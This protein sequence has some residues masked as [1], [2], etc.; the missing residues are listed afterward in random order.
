MAQVTGMS[1]ERSFTG[2]MIA[3]P[4]LLADHREFLLASEPVNG[5]RLPPDSAAWLSA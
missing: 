2:L 1:L 3:V 4:A 5:D